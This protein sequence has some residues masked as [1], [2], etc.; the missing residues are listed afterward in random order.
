MPQAGAVVGVVGGGGAVVGAGELVCQVVGEGLGAG[1]GEVA[2]GVV[3]VVGGGAAF[4]GG[5]E[6]VCGVVGVGRCSRCWGLFRR[7]PA[8]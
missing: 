6:L 4:D 1:G 3:G 2:V 5:G 7:G 8:R